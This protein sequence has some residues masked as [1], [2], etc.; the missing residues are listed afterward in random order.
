MANGWDL[1]DRGPI[2]AALRSE[3]ATARG[4]GVTADPD[5]ADVTVFGL[6]PAALHDSAGPGGSSPEALS[7][8]A[9]GP[10]AAD[11]IPAEE[12]PQPPRRSLAERFK[13]RKT[14]DTKEPRKGRARRS[15]LSLETYA[16]AAW[17]GAAAIVARLGGP[18]LAPVSAIMAWEEPVAGMVLDE[19]IRGTF[20]DPPLQALAR[21]AESGTDAALLLGPPVIVGG[22]CAGI[23]PYPVG[24]AML[25][26]ILKN[27]VVM[28]GPRIREI[29]EREAEFA[30]EMEQ[31]TMPGP[32]GE[33]V[34]VSL[35]QIMDMI[36]A[37]GQVPDEGDAYAA[38][39]GQYSAAAG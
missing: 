32:D 35:D 25:G 15:R 9:A 4:E 22:V 37:A 30:R 33:P 29:A 7:A 13:S 38:A 24:R 39:N 11:D 19:A 6:P 16:G 1:S 34:P 31:M 3:Y 18:K 5:A 36:F 26:Q 8:P 21:F 27:Y 20:I 12:A 14:K 28:A 2:P 10:G 17:S 23:C